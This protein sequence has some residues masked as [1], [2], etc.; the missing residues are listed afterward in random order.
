METNRVTTDLLDIIDW[1]S[2]FSTMESNGFIKT[3]KLSIFINKKAEKYKN[4]GNIM[5]VGNRIQ[6]GS[7]RDTSHLYIISQVI[8]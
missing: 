3:T 7:I 4:P 2:F 6:S 8:F 1:S 5:L